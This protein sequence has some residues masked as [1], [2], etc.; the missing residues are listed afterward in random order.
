MALLR[1]E[2]KW[3]N[4]YEQMHDTLKGTSALF[5]DD[6]WKYVSNNG[7]LDMYIGLLNANEG[8]EQ[9][10]LKNS[11]FFL[12]TADIDYRLAVLNNEAVM[13]DDDLKAKDEET[14]KRRSFSQFYKDKTGNIFV[15]NRNEAKWKALEEQE[16]TDYEYNKILLEQQGEYYQYLYDQEKA[17]ENKKNMSG[18]QKVGT[19]VAQPFV[20]FFKQGI[21]AWQSIIDVFEGIGTYVFGGGSAKEREQRFREAFAI[22]PENLKGLNWLTNRIEEWELRD[23]VYRN[24]DGSYTNGYFELIDGIAGSFGQMLATAGLGGLAG[25]A[26]GAIGGAVGGTAGKVLGTTASTVAKVSNAL[27]YTSMAGENMQQYMADANFATTETW[28]LVLNSTLKATA[29]YAVQK[30]L[31]ALLGRATT[32]DRAFFGEKALNNFTKKAIEVSTPTTTGALQTIFADAVHEGIEETLQEFSGSMIDSF[33]AISDRQFINDSTWSLETFGNAFLLGAI[34]SGIASSLSVAVNG[35]DSRYQIHKGTYDGPT[36]VNALVRW[37]YSNQL[38]DMIQLT[39]EFVTKLQKGKL[40]SEQVVIGMSSISDMVQA[41][42]RVYGEIGPE[43]MQQAVDMLV[44]LNDY[45]ENHSFAKTET[46][47][48]NFVIDKIAN[49]TKGLEDAKLEYKDRKIAEEAKKLVEDLTAD[50]PKPISKDTKTVV[51]EAKYKRVA[52]DKGKYESLSFNADTD[53]TIKSEKPTLSESE[54]KARAQEK[55]R[56]TMQRK[57]D[58]D[59]AAKA[60]N[61]AITTQKELTIKIDKLNKDLEEKVAEREKLESEIA[62]TKTTEQRPTATTETLRKAS[63]DA[64]AAAEQKLRD[65]EKREALLAKVKAEQELKEEIKRL[66]QQKADAE[67]KR[68]KANKLTAEEKRRIAAEK[69]RLILKL[70]REALIYE[71]EAQSALEKVKYNYDAALEILGLLPDIDSKKAPIQKAESKWIKD[72]EN[73]TVAAS[74]NSVAAAIVATGATSVTTMIDAKTDWNALGETLGVDVRNQ[75]RKFYDFVGKDYT[76]IVTADGAKVVTEGN[77]IIVPINA[78]KANA[79]DALLA[80]VEYKFR[81]KI[82]KSSLLRRTIPKIQAIYFQLFNAE[83]SQEGAIAELLYNDL[84][85]SRILGVMDKDIVALMNVIN[86]TIESFSSDDKVDLVAKA[87]L[88]QVRDV[89]SAQITK[90]CLDNPRA[91]FIQQGLVTDPAAIKTIRIK[92]RAIAHSDSIIKNGVPKNIIKLKYDGAIKAGYGYAM[93]IN[94]LAL[95][96]SDKQILWDKLTTIGVDEDAQ[97]KRLATV[98]T[99]DSYLNNRLYGDYNGI[100]YMRSNSLQNNLF[101]EFLKSKGITLVDLEQLEQENHDEFNNVVFKWYDSG[102]TRYTVHYDSYAPLGQRFTIYDTHPYSSAKASLLEQEVYHSLSLD[103]SN[104]SFEYDDILFINGMADAKATLSLITNE[105]TDVFTLTDILYDP[106]LMKPELYTRFKSRLAEMTGS[107]DTNVS[108]S[109]VYEFLKGEIIDQTGDITIEYD[110]LGIPQFVSIEPAINIYEDPDWYSDI[111]NATEIDGKT[112]RDFLREDLKNSELADVKIRITDDRDG[113]YAD[114]TIYVPRVFGE[115][116][117]SGKLLRYIVTH[118]FQHAVQAFNHLNSGLSANFTADL[119][120]DDQI[121]IVKEFTDAMPDLFSDIV[122]KY[123][124]PVTGSGKIEI[125]GFAIA[126]DRINKFIYTRSGESVALGFEGYDLSYDFPVIVKI[127]GATLTVTLPSGGVYV[128]HERIQQKLTLNDH[129]KFAEDAKKVLDDVKQDLTRFDPRRPNKGFILVDGTIGFFDSR[130]MTHPEFISLI[131]ENAPKTDADYFTAHTVMNEAIQITNDSTDE[132]LGRDGQIQRAARFSDKNNLTV[133]MLMRLNQAQ[134]HALVRFIDWWNPMNGNLILADAY[135][136]RAY[137]DFNKW[138]ADHDGVPPSAHEMIGEYLRQFRRNNSNHLLRDEIDSSINYTQLYDGQRYIDF[139]NNFHDK[140]TKAYFD[141]EQREVGMVLPNGLYGFSGDASVIRDFKRS[142][143]YQPDNFAS[144]KLENLVTYESV[145]MTYEANRLNITIP[146]ILTNSQIETV[147]TLLRYAVEDGTAFS[148][149]DI[150]DNHICRGSTTADAVYAYEILSDESEKRYLQEGILGTRVGSLRTMHLAARRTSAD[151]EKDS[152]SI[153]VHEHVNKKGQSTYYKVFRV[154]KKNSADTN[155]TYFVGKDIHPDTAKFVVNA[156][157]SRLEPEVWQMIVNGTLTKPKAVEYMRETKDINDYTF[158]LMAECF[159]GNYRI[160]SQQELDDLMDFG[161]DTFYALR[162]VMRDLHW[163]DLLNKPL[164]MQGL[165]LARQAIEHNPD[166]RSMYEAIRGRFDT[167]KGKPLSIKDKNA[168]IGLLRYFDGTIERAGYVASIAKFSEINEWSQAG[169]IRT[170]SG[171]EARGHDKHGEDGQTLFDRIADTRAEESFEAL[172]D[173][174]PIEKMID[175]ILEVSLEKIRQMGKNPSA[176]IVNAL[177]SQIESKDNDTIRAMY[178]VLETAQMASAK[179]VRERYASMNVLD[180]VKAKP[181]RRPAGIKQNIR[182]IVARMRKHMS[183]HDTRRFMQ[184]EENQTYFNDDVTIKDE[185]LNTDDIAKLEEI[186]NLVRRVNQDVRT[187]MYTSQLAV[188][189]IKRLQRKNLRLTKKLEKANGVKTIIQPVFLNDRVFTIGTSVDMPDELMAILETTFE[190]FSKSHVQHLD[191]VNEAH[192]KMSY[193]NF[194]TQNAERLHGMDAATASNIID[195]YMKS[196]LLPGTELTE[197]LITKYETYKMYVLAF[198]YRNADEFDLSY[199]QRKF[200]RDTMHLDAHL[201]GTKLKAWG[202]VL[203]EFDTASV[204]MQAL[205]AKFNIEFDEDLLKELDATVRTGN[206]KKITEA[207]NKLLNDALTKYKG[208]KKS[209]LEKMWRFQRLAMLSSPGTWVRNITS[210]FIVEAGNKLSST[211]GHKLSQISKKY[212]RDID[213]Q[214]ELHGIKVNEDVKRFID[215]QILDSGLFNLIEDGFN[216]FDRDAMRKKRDGVTMTVDNR[217]VEA[218]RTS[219]E[220]RIM[221]SYQFDS[222]LLQR[223]ADW[224]GKMLSDNWWINRRTI[225]LFGRILQQAVDTGYTTTDGDGNKLNVKVDLSKGLTTDVVN[226]FADAYAEAS[227]EYMHK[228]NWVHDVE[229]AIRK[230][231]GDKG[232]FLY[233]QIFPFAASSWN[234]F[235]EMMNYTPFGIIKGIMQLHNLEKTIDKMD[236]QRQIFG[237]GPTSKFARYIAERNLGKGVIGSILIGLGMILGGLGIATIDEEDEK[238]KIKFADNFM[239]D[240]TSIFGSS[241]LLVGVALM[242]PAKGSF[243]EAFANVVD[244]LFSD[245][246]FSDMYNQFEFSD[247][248]GDWFINKPSDMLGTFVPNFLKALVSTTYNHE[249]DYH[250]GILGGLEYLVVSSIPGIAY[251]LPK[252]YDPFTGELQTKYK[253]PFIM[254]LINRFSPVK[255]Y[256]YD[257]SEAERIALGLGLQKGELTGRY[258]D[259]GTLGTADTAKLN[260]YYGQLNKTELAKL[261]N[262]NQKYRVLNNKGK[263]EELY[264]S[265]MT[266]EQK[267]SVINRIMA[268]NAKIAKIYIYT[269]NGGKYYASSSEYDELKKYGIKNLYKETTD[270]KGFM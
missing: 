269:S 131:T 238:I 95:S 236:T 162:A 193:R 154:T 58:A 101:N 223:G 221:S 174:V 251:A 86:S 98:R 249:I 213:D 187:G 259:I 240:I 139:L 256:S 172:F 200:I 212:R 237:Q 267:K 252:R 198:I 52:G 44:T 263:Y 20:S 84:F 160:K 203:H 49:V 105:D 21:G 206:V 195:F 117:V 7:G 196:S 74:S 119:Q 175:D 78:I 77:L 209:F 228:T 185:Y 208:H 197:Q 186:E 79:K 233:K 155:L 19:F 82:R 37:Q 99:I 202:Q 29:E 100:T 91:Y 167:Y 69:Q 264:F 253:V 178:S 126:L 42:M 16:L 39:N 28:K 75:L 146:D 53:S 151:T 40:S 138:T 265:R 130:L 45:A 62:T 122:E 35:I 199:D 241:S 10:I 76:V 137:V 43:R 15:D 6:D 242:N 87:R 71:D 218:I 60:N 48:H 17:A 80:A 110:D 121:R 226:M 210:N 27:Y 232:M 161:L 189:T 142:M 73:R 234:W 171:D 102:Y 176:A 262:N 108:P 192:L 261:I 164:S 201:A 222:K 136:N 180:K 182:N 54:K 250:S 72:E 255:I 33:F 127:D 2:Q 231:F 61:D 94:G 246:I 254:E 219:I 166:V 106:S 217:L 258:E 205:A 70:S 188:D 96:D 4:P 128:V 244:T 152:T 89:I 109:Y 64:V 145:K 230:R 143:L 26:V 120:P 266:D 114:G 124:P 3:A 56:I 144:E 225:S 168:K 1:A 36:D 177:R 204:V 22:D 184:V 24:I 153:Q 66:K 93:L 11:K 132:F 149:Y 81:N 181:K 214:Y 194:L 57:K 179:A 245:S 30:G 158:R 31:K 12:P 169:N 32:M 23:A 190:E 65:D 83:V 141:G 50:T 248:I 90:F 140:Y 41:L 85:M 207:R 113:G 163:D 47:A 55:R 51:D 92:E 63:D 173:E 148:I 5:N 247:N 25:K 107:S 8:R 270:K 224:L 14:R 46:Q 13:S 103:D 129:P 159:F 229:H 135:N 59:A 104:S 123:G 67:A 165:E 9:E 211:I 257:V 268:D 147:T 235:M 220:Y 118:E 34:S 260:E 134:Y 243:E 216:K 150:N 183:A 239:V 157:Q 38:R 115:K 227:W 191:E 215:K 156:D 18:W 116:I 133:R 125:H 68:V 88:K 112:M 111:K 97:R 170:T